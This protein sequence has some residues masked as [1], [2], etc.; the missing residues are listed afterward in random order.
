MRH[1]T[2]NEIGR[3]EAMA[4]FAAWAEDSLAKVKAAAGMMS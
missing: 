2:L 1:E 3:E 4:E